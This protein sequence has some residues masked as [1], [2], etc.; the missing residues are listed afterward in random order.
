MLD[1]CFTFLRFR[2]KDP[3]LTKLPEGISHWSEAHDSYEAR[4][5]WLLASQ[6]SRHCSG[7]KTSLVL[8]L[9]GSLWQQ[10]YTYLHIHIHVYGKYSCSMIIHCLS[11]DFTRWNTLN[12]LAQ[13]NTY[14]FSQ[15]S[16]PFTVGWHIASQIPTWKAKCYSEAGGPWSVSFTFYSAPSTV[17]GIVSNALLIQSC[18]ILMPSFV[19]SVCLCYNRLFWNPFF[20]FSQPRVCSSGLRSEYHRTQKEKTV[21]VL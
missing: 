21:T 10:I 19:R 2:H 13:P 4:D 14:V 20:H 18:P 11:T 8:T 5:P 1:A 12:I 6:N 16:K 17:I 15:F 3:L 9:K 7:N